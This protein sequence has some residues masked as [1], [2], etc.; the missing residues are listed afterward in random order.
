VPRFDPRWLDELKLSADIVQIVQHYV[1]LKR[2]GSTY[3]GLCPFHQEKTPSFHV[4]RERGFFHC[5]GC[6]VGGDVFK[7]VELAERVGFQEAVRIVAERVGLPVP[8]GEE[9]AAERAA[10]AEREALVAVH[11]RAARFFREQLVAPGGAPARAQLAE[12]GLAPDTVDALG[13]GYAPRTGDSLARCL[14]AEGFARPLLLKSGLV[15]ERADGRLRDRFRGRLM[16]P[17]CRESGVVIGFG[18]RACDPGDE[19]KYLNSPD[20]PIF[21]KGRLLYGL[22]LSKQAIRREGYA[23]VVEGYFDFAQVW[24]AGIA[25]VVASCGT[26]LTPAQVRLL[27]RFAPR[28]VLSFDPDPAGQGATARSCELLVSEGLEVEVAL[29]PEGQDPDTVIRTAGAQAYRDRLAAARPYLEFLLDRTAAAF[30]LAR[31]ADRRAFLDR[32]LAVAARIPDPAVRDQ[33]ADRLAHKARITEEVVR[34]EIRRAAVRREPT[35]ARALPAVGPL[36]PAEKGLLWALMR[37][38]AEALTALTTLEPADLEGLATEAVLLAARGLV[39][40]PADTVPETLLE[41]LNEQ[42]AHLLRTVAAEPAAAAPPDACARALKRLR[43]ERERAAVQHEIDRLQ[44]QG[45]AASMAR[46][47]ALWVRKKELLNLIEALGA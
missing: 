18:A 26:A 42:E 17:V 13:L 46:I 38:P 35:A 4:H 33:F 43:Y 1:P 16:I 40:W 45:G 41:R 6:G 44:Q 30:N 39:D 20:T 8:E 21:S 27:K 7:F 37:T 23:V 19:P 22:H 2:S 14:L 12:R 25:P 29:L 3:R 15:V 32:M 28:V 10:A 31:E 34:A 47:D 11:E 9:S 24:Q 5:F 36:R